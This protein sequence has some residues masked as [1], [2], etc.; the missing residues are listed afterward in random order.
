MGITGVPFTVID[1]KYA[2]SG[3]Q[4]IETFAEI[5]GKLAKGE[6]LGNFS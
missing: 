2:V 5:F 4:D 1:S 6:E 3:A